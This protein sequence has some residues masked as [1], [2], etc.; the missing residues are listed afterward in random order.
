MIDVFHDSP[1]CKQW[2]S[3]LRLTEN[4]EGAHLPDALSPSAF[5][6]ACWRDGPEQVDFVVERWADTWGIE[7]ES[8]RVQ[9]LS[10][11]ASFPVNFRRAVCSSRARNESILSRSLL[12]HAGRL[13]SRGAGIFFIGAGVHQRLEMI[14]AGTAQFEDPAREPA[15]KGAI[16]GHEQHR[17]IEFAEG[18]H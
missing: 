11:L 16:V 7:V 9:K 10:G 18:F 3:R 15:Q 17:S 6:I 2:V 12:V 8:G 4:A 1:F 5:F 14:G 13:P